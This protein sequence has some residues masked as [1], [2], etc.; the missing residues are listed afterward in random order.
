MTRREESPNTPTKEETRLE[1]SP[2]TPTTV[3]HAL[4]E[5]VRWTK[6]VK[7]TRWGQN[8]KR[9]KEV[10]KRVIE[11]SEAQSWDVS[12]DPHECLQ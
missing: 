11:M 6:T 10:V 9:V 1:E 8:A 7:L 4:P 12:I 5:E 3:S 2:S